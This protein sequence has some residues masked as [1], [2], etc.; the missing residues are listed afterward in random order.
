MIVEEIV[1]EIAEDAVEVSEEGVVEANVEVSEGE[2]SD[3]IVVADEVVMN[4]LV[5]WGA[6]VVGRGGP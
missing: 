6:V 1:E 2:D 5:M 3:S 4:V